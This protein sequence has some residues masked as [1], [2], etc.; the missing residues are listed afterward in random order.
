MHKRLLQA[1]AYQIITELQDKFFTLSNP[2]IVKIT[3]DKKFNS[4]FAAMYSEKEFINDA[5]K[6]EIIHQIKISFDSH[7]Q[8]DENLA[9]T[10]AHELVHAEQ[11]EKGKNDLKHDRAFF[12]R[13][14]YILHRIGL[15]PTSFEY[16]QAIKKY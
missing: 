2:V 15:P 7:W 16:R 3:E 1:K 4:I 5:G 12:S 14:D 6:K 10:L 9:E 13:L 8:N 11:N